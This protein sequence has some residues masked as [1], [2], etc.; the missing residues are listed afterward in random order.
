MSFDFK[1]TLAIFSF[2]FVMHYFSPFP[3]RQNSRI[4]QTERVCRR[5]FEI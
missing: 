1:E 5:Q 3:K 4:F 2:P